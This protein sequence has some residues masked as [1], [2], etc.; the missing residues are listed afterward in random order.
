MAETMMNGKGLSPA[1]GQLN[2]LNS[3]SNQNHNLINAHGPN[4]N[5]NGWP[6]QDSLSDIELFPRPP[7]IHSHG[8]GD[9]A[10]GGGGG[11]QNGNGGNGNKG[12]RGGKGG[13]SVG[14]SGSAG[15]SR[16]NGHSNFAFAKSGAEE[17]DDGFQQLRRRSFE[18]DDEIGVGSMP[19]GDAFGGGG[20][21]GPSQWIEWSQ[22]SVA[23]FVR[24]RARCLRVIFVAAFAL[25]YHYILGKHNQFG[26]V[27]G[28]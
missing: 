23:G 8:D 9:G 1:A 13:L 20:G 24:R 5:N 15:R 26:V 17:G 25:L 27:V 12:R 16:G 4:G 6:S 3:N 21:G 19:S 2:N 10:G 14:G 22:E 18:L 11:E 7:K 28:C